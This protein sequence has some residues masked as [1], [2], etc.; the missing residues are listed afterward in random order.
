M[1]RTVQ[2]MHR[3]VDCGR[4]MDDPE[5]PYDLESLTN[6]HSSPSG[7]RQTHKLLR[8]FQSIRNVLFSLTKHVSLF[9]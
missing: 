8:P 3:G 7:R 6:L 9:I 4:L 2:G 5:S 1:H